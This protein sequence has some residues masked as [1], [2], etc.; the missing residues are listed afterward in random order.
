MESAAP[1]TTGEGANQTLAYVA[2][3]LGILSLICC[4]WLIPGVIAI[5][6]G[7]IA[8]NKALSDP[9]NYGGAKYAM[10]GMVLGGIS[11]VLGIV[12]V[13]AWFLLGGLGSLI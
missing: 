6:V 7:F 13:I 5:I 1:E 2:L 9:E 12:L 8:R 10:I 3:G 11:I 4:T